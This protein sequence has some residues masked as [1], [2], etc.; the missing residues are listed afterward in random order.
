MNNISGV[1][2]KTKIFSDRTLEKI[3]STD[4]FAYTR[5]ILF[6]TTLGMFN[7]KQLWAQS[8]GAL[9]MF[10][11]HPI[12]FTR[13][14]LAAPFVFTGYAVRNTPAFKNIAKGLSALTGISPKDFD[15]LLKYFDTYGTTMGTYRMPMA[16]RVNTF[17]TIE[18]AGA[19]L[20]S[21]VEFGTN[22]ANV[23]NDIA[24]Y[25][26]APVKNFKDCSNC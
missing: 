8:L 16:E 21:P 18:K 9:N 13:A 20:R 25:L 11:T 14:M 2:A 15:N 22:I 12:A 23:V 3:A 1:F 6:Q 4:P 17:R 26:S 7:L 10:P 24:A 5:A 19:I